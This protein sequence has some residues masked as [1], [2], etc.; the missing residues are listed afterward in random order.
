MKIKK[1][2]AVALCL[3]F[4]AAFCFLGFLFKEVREI[5]LMQRG[6]GGVGGEIAIF[7]IPVVVYFVYKNAKDL[8]SCFK[9]GD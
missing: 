1:V 6:H 2:L 5:A 8:I 9:E 4:L 7:F 3:S